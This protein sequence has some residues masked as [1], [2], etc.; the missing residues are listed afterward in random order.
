MNTAEFKEETKKQRRIA[1]RSEAH[2]HMHE[3]AER[4]RKITAEI[5]N[6]FR[7]QEE[8][9]KLFSEL[10]GQ[11]VDDGFCL[12]PPFYSDYGQ[13]ITVGKNVFINSGCCFQDQGG[14]EIGDNALIG[15]QTVIATLN[16]D[17]TPQRRADMFPAPVKIGNGVW[18]GAHSTI[19]A[20][21]TI[22][23]GAVVAAGAVVTKDVPENVAVA[24][25]P[26]KIIKTIKE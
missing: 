26:A 19:L 8:L 16:H 7:T 21:V 15:Q 22:G 9:R 12:F 14:I 23:N 10:T 2:L 25:V 1:A 11:K 4:A 17:L 3:A 6:T 5:N 20:G 13:N 18:I 24:G